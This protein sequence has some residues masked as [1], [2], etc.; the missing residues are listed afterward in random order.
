MLCRHCRVFSIV[1]VGFELLVIREFTHSSSLTIPQ[2]HLAQSLQ[3]PVQCG[4]VAAVVYANEQNAHVVQDVH[5][6]A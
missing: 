3:E 2:Q 4:V 1:Y 5:N 6:L